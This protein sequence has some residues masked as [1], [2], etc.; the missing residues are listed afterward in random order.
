MITFLTCCYCLLGCS[1]LSPYFVGGLGEGAWEGCATV[2]RLSITRMPLGLIPSMAAG[3]PPRAM[4]TILASNCMWHHSAL[5]EL[6]ADLLL[7]RE[8]L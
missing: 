2:E 4:P 3:S 5:D 1:R 8:L 7:T 6:L